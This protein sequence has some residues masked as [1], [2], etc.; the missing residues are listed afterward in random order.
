M[1]KVSYQISVGVSAGASGI[2]GNNIRKSLDEGRVRSLNRDWPIYALK[3]L[4]ARQPSFPCSS[5]QGWIRDSF[6]ITTNQLMKRFPP[7]SFYHWA[8][9]ANLPSIREYGLLSTER[10]TRL[11]GLTGPERA[12]MLSQYRPNQVELP[13]GIVIRDQTPMPPALLAKALP[14]G[15][16]PSDWYRL[17]NG[18]VFLWGSPERAER[19]RVAFAGSPQVL[20]VFDAALL[21]RELGDRVLL[22]PINS[23]NARRRPAPR[24]RSLFVPYRE[25]SD[26]GWPVI[27]GQRRSRSVM[28]AEIVLKGHLPLEPFLTDMRKQ[29]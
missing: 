25:W 12:A 14:P 17:L 16:S 3:V 4:Y 5:D 23:G 1:E 29:P 7:S 11:A 22:S 24:S 8:D 10:L 2:L 18:F 27:E 28:P 13:N 9:P 19:H 21:L 15:V 6:T 26:Q 20:L